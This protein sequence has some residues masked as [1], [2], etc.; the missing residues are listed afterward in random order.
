VHAG[1]V[2]HDE[3]LTTPYMHNLNIK[4]GKQWMQETFGKEVRGLWQIDS[5]GA[6]HVTPKVL[7]GELDHIVLNRIGDEAKSRLKAN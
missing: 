3:T 7:E 1:W 2:Q 4:I 5:F 6:S